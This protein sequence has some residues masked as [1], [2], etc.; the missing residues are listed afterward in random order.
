MKLRDLIKNYRDTHDLS[1]RQFANQCG[2]SNGYIS[3]LEKGIN[4]KTGKPVTPTIPQLKKL[5]DGMAMTLNELFEQVDD[6][7]VSLDLGGIKNIVPFPETER[8][9]RIGRIACGDPI[10]AEENIENY[11]EVLSSWRADF[12]LMCVG[13]SMAP[14]IENGDIVA[15]RAQPTVDNGEI[16]AVRIGDEATLKRVFLHSDYIEL[17]PINPNYDSIIRRKN[18]TEDIRIEGRAVGLCRNL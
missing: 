15:I 3:I 11:D 4:P 2:L 10:I 17:R 7:P 1:Q 16:A 9:P 12:T 13:D 6:M 5:A 14:K 8:K 18:E